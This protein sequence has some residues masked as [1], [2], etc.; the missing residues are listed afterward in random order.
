IP[1]VKQER[2]GKILKDLKEISKILPTK[3]IIGS[4]YLTDE[5]II[6]VSQIVKKAGAINYY[7]L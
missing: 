1:D 3:V 6:K 5:E 7:P 4:G 2:W